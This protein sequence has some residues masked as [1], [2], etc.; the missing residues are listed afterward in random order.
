MQGA[1]EGKGG[2]GKKEERLEND[3]S[4]QTEVPRQQ[5]GRNWTC[6]LILNVA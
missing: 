5:D 2:G 3:G 4:L 1:G 6:R